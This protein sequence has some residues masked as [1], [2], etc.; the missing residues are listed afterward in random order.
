[1][2]RAYTKATSH[3][4]GYNKS[5]SWLTKRDIRMK[6]GKPKILI[7]P[8]NAIGTICILYLLPYYVLGTGSHIMI[9]DNLDSNASVFK[10][11]AS[12]NKLFSSNS[13]LIPQ[14]F[15]GIPRGCFPS[16]FNL[17]TILYL[18]LK[19][20]SAYVADRTL[21]TIVGYTG[22][23]LLL[24]HHVNADSKIKWIAAGV[25]ACFA[26]L[27]FWPP[28]L[29]VAGTPLILFAFLNIRSGR[30]NIIDWLIIAL[31]P[32]CASLITT[33]LFLIIVIAAILICDYCY[34][35][36]INKTVIYGLVLLS[37]LFVV[38]HYRLFQSFILH[39]GY[40]SH[41]IEFRDT[42]IG[43]A[44]AIKRAINL[45][46]W[47]QDHALSLQSLV[48]IPTTTLATW[49]MI[50][51]KNVGKKYIFVCVFIVISSAFYG[52]W[53]WDKIIFIKE[54]Q[55]SILPIQL[56]RFHW[57][58]PMSWFIVFGI[59][60]Y[61]INNRLHIGKYIAITAIFLQ[62]LY[63]FYYNETYR[64]RSSP[65]YEQ[66]YAIRQFAK[67][68]QY[69]HQPT[70]SYRVVS[71]GLY[72][73]IALYND[74]YVLDG[75][76]ADYPLSYKHKFGKVI[77]NEL[78]KNIIAKQYFDDWGSR[79]YIFASELMPNYSENYKE[80]NKTIDVLDIN[81]NA[82]YEIGCRYI[83]SSVKINKINNQHLLFIKKFEDVNS[84]WDIYLYQIIY[85]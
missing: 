39:S 33:G 85:G 37:L 1:V 16:E 56:Q 40:V 8:F 11:L 12:S 49:L 9:W 24:I 59:S 29:S 76:I 30:N 38:S 32:F 7:T 18:Y 43:F 68:K 78:D 3:H 5:M 61:E 81:Y 31:Y 36:T 50:K 22:M 66:F 25:A 48:I 47:G 46:V 80:K 83:I 62:L 45:G 58:H 75:Y 64:Y 52:L 60:L 77:R 82:L 19:P 65:T 17:T 14:I 27:P 79:A 74:F 6:R 41:R 4:R 26:L 21:M 70:A 15:N 69:I 53:Y 13:T 44:A 63:G 71:L 51:H 73:S 84:A 42:G 10:I 20:Y 54:Y 67:I 72:P 35:K 57:L 55:Q 2:D 34:N 23:Y 28:G